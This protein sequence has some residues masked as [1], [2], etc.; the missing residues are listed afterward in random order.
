MKVGTGNCSDLF[1]KGYS[2]TMRSAR[3]KGFTKW[4]WLTT[5]GGRGFPKWPRGHIGPHEH[6]IGISE[7]SCVKLL[8]KK[9]FMKKS[10]KQKIKV[11]RIEGGSG[12]TTWLLEGVGQ[13]TPFDHVGGRER[14]KISKNP[15]AWHM[16]VPK[17]C[18]KRCTLHWTSWQE[19]KYLDFDKKILSN[20]T[21]K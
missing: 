19:Q 10:W 3:G 4:P 7:K 18:Y 6:W 14:V 11:F 2:Y 21:E 8:S 9:M 16:N 20:F 15:T 12:L 13:M 1:E 5:R 17:G